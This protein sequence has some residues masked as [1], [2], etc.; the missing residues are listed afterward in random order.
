MEEFELV[1]GLDLCKLEL[2]GSSGLDMLVCLGWAKFMP[3]A[4]YLKQ[5][6]GLGNKFWSPCPQGRVTNLQ[7]E[8]RIWGLESNK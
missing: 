1:E 3:D 7:K 5:Y 6:L 4:F 8:H 2:W